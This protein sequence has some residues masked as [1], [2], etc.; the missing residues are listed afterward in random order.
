MR[1]LRVNQETIECPYCAGNGYQPFSGTEC[2]WCN[3]TGLYSDIVNEIVEDEE[4]S[5]EWN[6]R[7]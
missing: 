7:H 5:V 2:S 4:D 1:I 6:E 3:G